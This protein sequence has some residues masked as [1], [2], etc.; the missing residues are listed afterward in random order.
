LFCCFVVVAASV[1][2]VENYP[3]AKFAP[4]ADVPGAVGIARSKVVS[5]DLVTC[6]SQLLKSYMFPHG[7]VVDV[8]AV[9]WL[10]LFSK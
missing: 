2:P 5:L 1:L 6:T 9:T 7:T 8:I 3:S 10:L 4:A